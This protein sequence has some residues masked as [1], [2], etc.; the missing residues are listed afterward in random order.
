MSVVWD[1]GSATVREVWEAL[2]PSRKLAYTTVAT[3]LRQ[4]EKKGL[5][6]H[7]VQDRT[8]VFSPTVGRED[9]SQGLVA[10]LVKGVFE[11]SAAK[12]VLTLIQNERLTTRELNEIKQ[13]IDA[14]HR[15]MGD[16]A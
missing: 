5:L 3:M 8:Y 4:I 15:N 12:L 6:R 11:G 1:R 9:V 10:D 13:L 16:D 2:H 14:Q 7:T